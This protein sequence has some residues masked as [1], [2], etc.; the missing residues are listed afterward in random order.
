MS[1]STV[2]IKPLQKGGI[3]K[4][5]F[6]HFLLIKLAV[7]IIHSV[8]C[9]TIVNGETVT[10]SILQNTQPMIIDNAIRDLNTSVDMDA[11]QILANESEQI[12][13]EDVQTENSLIKGCNCKKLSFYCTKF[14]R[15]TCEVLT[16]VIKYRKHLKY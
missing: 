8:S 4:G 14:R 1:R 12:I 6:L 11:K 15:S 10:E 2:I 3:N 16:F 13:N 7:T 5:L 9:S